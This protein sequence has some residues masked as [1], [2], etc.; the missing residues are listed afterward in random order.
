M[1]KTC[2]NSGVVLFS[3]GL[4]SG[5][6]LSLIGLNSGVVLFLRVFIVESYF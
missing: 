4:N 5:V 2:L 3:S 6:V 1:A